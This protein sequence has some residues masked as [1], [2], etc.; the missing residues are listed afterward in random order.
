LLQSLLQIVTAL[1]TWQNFE[2]FKN[3][4]ASFRPTGFYLI[5]RIK[6]KEK[7]FSKLHLNE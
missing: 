3:F 4:E 1:L 6:K 7:R 2:S 5:V